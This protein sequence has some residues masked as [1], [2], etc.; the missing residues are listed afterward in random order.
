MTPAGGHEAPRGYCDVLETP[1]G[2]L[3]QPHGRQKNLLR[4]F[5]FHKKTRGG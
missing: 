2:F 3:W 4:K 5:V 1:A